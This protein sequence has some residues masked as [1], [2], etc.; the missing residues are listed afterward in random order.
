[1]KTLALSTSL[2]RSSLR[3]RR[4]MLRIGGRKSSVVPPPTRSGSVRQAVV[5]V[6]VPRSLPRRIFAASLAVR[7]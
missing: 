6:Y 7:T 3:M 1:M 5:G 4:K 2:R